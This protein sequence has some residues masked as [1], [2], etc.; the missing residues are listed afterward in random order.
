MSDKPAS[1]G[2]RRT[3]ATALSLL[4]DARGNQAWGACL[5][6]KIIRR[7]GSIAQCDGATF[8]R[9]AK[10]SRIMVHTRYATHGSITRKNC[11]P[12]TQGDVVGCH[13]GVIHNHWELNDY[14]RRNFAVDS[15]HIFQHIDEQAPLDDLEGYGAIQ[16]HYASDPSTTYLARFNGGELSFAS[17]PWGCAWSST[18]HDLRKSLDMAGLKYN[19]HACDESVLYF[20]RNGTLWSTQDRITIA[21]PRRHVSWRDFAEVEKIEKSSQW[22]KETLPF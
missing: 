18:W 15:Q 7:V 4:N 10:S 22:Q 16:Y 20:A 9:I 1:I 8:S 11:H 21:K 19:R 6:D 2:K 17:G 14:L 3:M 13:N 12:F 5:D